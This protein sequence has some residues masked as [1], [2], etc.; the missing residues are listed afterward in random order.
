MID[1]DR[2][3]CWR[4]GMRHLIAVV[5]GLAV[6]NGCASV[7]RDAR[8]PQVQK[9]ASSRLEQNV[10][11]NR[12]SDQD[13]L[14]REAVQRLLKRELAPDGA[15]QIALLNN[16]ELQATY[17]R[18]GIA[19]ADLVQAGL[20]EN[21][22][23]SLTIVKGDAGSIIEGSV[24]QDFV[25]VFSLSARKKIGEA[26]A[27]RVTLEVAHRAVD[28]AKQVQAQY[29]T[30]AS[31]AEA[32]ELAR[33]VVVATD[34]AA[35]LAERQRAAGNLNRRDQDLQQ[36]FYAQTLL[37][38]AQAETQL[39]SDRERLNRLM[40]LWGQDV[41]WKLPAR[42]PKVPDALPPVD[43][44]EAQAIAQRL[45]LAVAKKDAESAAQALNLT[46]EFR[47]LSRFGIGVAYKREPDFGAL[48]GPTVELGLP[49]FDQGQARVVRAQVE[50]KRS[51]ERVAALAVDIRSE[52]REARAR[53]TAAHAVVRHYQTA[54]LP[55]Q[56]NIVS[57]TLKLYNGML[58]GVYDLLLAK[59]NQILTARQYITSSRDF[60][61]A[62]TDLERTVGGKLPRPASAS[63]EGQSGAPT[64]TAPPKPEDGE[65]GDPDHPL[66]H[67]EQKP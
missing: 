12:D 60:W 65:G 39:T 9:A 47:Y 59:Q 55:L 44:V 35:E 61:L 15:V 2:R 17:E 29:Y 3:R 18:L 40:G 23:F 4:W 51:Q 34:A 63:S 53:L 62:W 57:E 8:F 42:L 11:W 26:A 43:Q 54:L 64:T 21:P 41:C 33:Q 46:R 67:G 27:Q 25:S 30:T 58:V 19:Q 36:A 13:R 31:G 5:L 32:L 24:V 38:V 22:V 37:D 10:V 50:F 6:L 56:Q 16:R 49:I 66:Q 28:L 20:L 14:A 1:I 45:D 48:V 7:R 52:A